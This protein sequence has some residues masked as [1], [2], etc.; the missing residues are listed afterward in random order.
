MDQINCET[1][2]LIVTHES[3]LSTQVPSIVI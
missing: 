2:K 1:P 3:Q